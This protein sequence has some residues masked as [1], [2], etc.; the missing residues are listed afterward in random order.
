MTTKHHGRNDLIDRL[1][2]QVGGN[3]D[4]ALS[5]LRD[6]GHIK[7]DSE[8]FTP[9]GAARNKMTA[10]ERAKDRASK[11]SGKPTTNYSY[12]LKTNRATLKKD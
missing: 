10:E 1:A 4:M 5:I 7:A 6:R 2:A 3:R 12:S 11:L 8:E 9:A